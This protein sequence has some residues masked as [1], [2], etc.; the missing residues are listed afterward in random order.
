VSLL[1]VTYPTV[2]PS[3]A[4]ILASLL[5]A[6]PIGCTPIAVVNYQHGTSFS[7]AEVPSEADPAGTD[8]R[9]LQAA[10]FAGHGYVLVA[11]DYLGLGASPGRHPFLHAATE[12]SAVIDGWRA[13]RQVAQ[14]RGWSWPTVAFLAGFSQGGHAT[15]AVLKALPADL[16]ARAVAG[17]SG[18]YNLSTVQLAFTL[19]GQTPVDS[20]YLGYILS[21]YAHLYVAPSPA[22]Y[23]ESP[24]DQNLDDLFDGS[25]TIEDIIERV[26]PTPRDLITSE[27]ARQL[28]SREPNWFAAALADNDVDAL[29]SAI[30]I[31]LYYSHA[32]TIVDPAQAALAAARLR[33]AGGLAETV[34]VGEVDHLASWLVALGAVRGWFDELLR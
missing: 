31:R 33:G 15:L 22:A 32:D 18:P 25:K 23:L 34:D 29:T 5:M 27:F 2:D 7:R 13:A 24:Y 14:Q 16:Q 17:I 30:P 4:P 21:S 6:T 1:Q 11:A 12:A 10:A 26:P 28:E 20:A 3:G 9:I 8:D 19:S